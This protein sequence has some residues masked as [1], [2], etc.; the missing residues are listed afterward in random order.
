ME[1]C[2]D[3]KKVYKLQVI[4]NLKQ[5]G[6]YKCYQWGRNRDQLD[7]QHHTTVASLSQLSVVVFFGGVLFVLGM[8]WLPI[9][10]T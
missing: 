5:T 8:F 1:H 7:V 4:V 10:H 2:R 9:A 3:Q 6:K